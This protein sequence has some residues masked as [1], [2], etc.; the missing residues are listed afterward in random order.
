MPLA[1]FWTSNFKIE[2]GLCSGIDQSLGGC[3]L[4]HIIFKM[5]LGLRK[6]THLLP[7]VN[8]IAEYKC[9]DTYGCNVHHTRTREIKLNKL[10][11][12]R[13]N[14]LVVVDRFK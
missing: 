14:K 4:F 5:K 1:L 7:L 12:E 3:F 13:I 11:I 2:A 10:G 8:L 9:E 6:E